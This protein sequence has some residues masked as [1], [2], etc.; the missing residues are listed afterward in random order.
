LG[1]PCLQRLL[2]QLVHANPRFGPPRLA[3]IDVADG[4]YRVG[5]RPADIPKLG[6]ILPHTSTGAP[7]VAFPLALPMGWVESPPFFTALTET[8]C[9]LANAAT[10]R[11][12]AADLPRV[13]PL[14]S[15]SQTP[16]P[17]APARPPSL[18]GWASRAHA[19]DESIRS[20]PLAMVDVY[21]DDFLLGAQT[22]REQTRL[23][24]NTLHAIDSVF[25]PLEPHDP[26]SRK[27]PASV[28]KMRQGDAHW[29]YRKQMLGWVVDTVRETIEL[30]PHRLTRLYA[31]LDDLQPPR[32]RMAIAQWH[33]LLG[34]LR[35]M[36]LAI[37]GSTGL[38][39]ILQDTLR[40]GDKHRVRCRLP[41]SGG[42]PS[43][44]AHSLS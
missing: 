11:R 6:V 20:T 41:P 16:A 32:K 21:V 22:K 3:K 30:P 27:A 13:H 37:P 4:F 5:L 44:P 39:S 40:R 42:F 12:G 34:E 25:R 1:A 43:L 24:R 10:L 9:D 2:S 14:E 28:K 23:L 7:L 17:D 35:S 33:R 38:F 31:L 36:A 15:V 8:A 18:V 26:S 19:F 29:A